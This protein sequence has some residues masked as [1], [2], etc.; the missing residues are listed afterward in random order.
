MSRRDAIKLGSAA[1]A[2]LI[3]PTRQLASA[4]SDD[5]LELPPFSVPLS[6]PPVLKPTRRTGDTDFYDMRI[7]ESEHEILPGIRTRALTFNGG[8]PGPTIRAHRGRAVVIRQVN[9]LTSPATVHLHGAN[10]PASSDGH[11]MD[12]IAPGQSRVYRYPNDQPAATLWYHDHTHHLEGEQV[13]RGLSGAYLLSDPVDALLPLPSGEF[14]VPLQLRD[15]KLN[16]DGQLVFVNDD[17]MNRPTILVNGRPQP[18]FE[19]KRRLYRLRLI[20]VSNLEVFKFQLSN[21]A[22]FLQIA[23][24]GG[25][26]RVPAVRQEIDLWPA[27]RA[28][29]LVDFRSVPSGTAVALQNVVALSENK[30]DILQFRIGGGASSSKPELA[31]PGWTGARLPLAQAGIPG[32]PSGNPPRERVAKRR[33]FVLRFDP[34]TGEFLINDQGFDPNRVDAKIEHGSTEI[35]ELVNGDA[36]FGITHTMHLHL[37]QFRVLD[38][39]GKPEPG[40]DAYPKDTVRLSPGDVVRIEATFNTHTGRYP[41]HCHFLDHATHSMMGQFEV[42]PRR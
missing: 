28:E 27:E 40:H 32:W 41:F 11:P 24:D 29:V 42:V 36:A 30:R 37:V 14:D 17:F 31:I 12:P 8:F 13:Y 38:R 34:A 22:R 2:A 39:N 21:G 33:R 5:P 9:G 4:L 18:Y 23:S 26:L 3:F 10:V 19:V 7:A 25:F 20:N 16:G 15:A 6:L 1:G 35:W